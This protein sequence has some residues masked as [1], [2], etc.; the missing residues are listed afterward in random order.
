MKKHTRGSVP[1]L[2]SSLSSWLLLWWICLSASTLLAEDPAVVRLSYVKDSVSVKQPDLSVLSHAVANLPLFSGSTVTTGPE[3]EAEIEFADGS[4]ARLTPNSS[5]LMTHL[6]PL[7][8]SGHTDLKLTSG[9]AYF[10]LNVGQGQRFAVNLG[11]AV[12][13][14]LENSIFRVN[15]D[16]LPE[17]AVIRGSLHVDAVGGSSDFN[18]ELTANQSA[19]FDAKDPASSVVAEEV[20]PDSWDQWNIDRDTAIAQQA[21]KQTPVRDSSQA[22]NDPG[23]NDLDAAGNWYPVDGYG[24]VWTPSNVDAGWDPFAYGYWGNFQG[25]GATW[26]SGYS[27]GWLPYHCGAW[28]YFPFGW[29]WVP[30]GCGGGWS[31][32]VTVWN[33]PPNYR[34]PVWP[35]GGFIVPSQQRT[36]LGRRLIA[37]DRRPGSTPAGVHSQPGSTGS[38]AFGNRGMRSSAAS[39]SSASVGASAGTSA[40]HEQV[41]QMNGR[42][43]RPIAPVANPVPASGFT[44]GAAAHVGVPVSRSTLMNSGIPTRDHV[45]VHPGGAGSS[46]APIPTRPSYAP[47]VPARMAPLQP[48]RSAAPPPSAPAHVA[49]PPAAAGRPH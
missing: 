15:L 22:P 21:E 25:Y 17:G 8:G 37:V 49:A 39:S 9:L 40:D 32:L 48:A 19:R 27:W 31:P 1:F 5:L 28:N 44:Q 7:G 12:L 45:L 2:H 26:I 4:V 14:P 43:I 42:T 41:I 11:V 16:K 18:E 30:G 23:W 47:S 6:Q 34:L 36:P 46:I 20:A 33:T 29:G 10:E 38:A 13:R 35:K 3:G 24:D